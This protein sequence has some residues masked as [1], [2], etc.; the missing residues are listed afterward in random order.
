MH[1]LYTSERFEHHKTGKHPECSDR[2]RVLRELIDRPD[3]KQNWQI[4][5]P[6]KADRKIL[7]HIH[8]EKHIAAIEQLSMRGDGRIAADTVVSKASFDIGMNAECA[9]EIFSMMLRKL[10]LSSRWSRC[11]NLQTGVVV[12]E[13]LTS[14]ST[15][16]A[17]ARA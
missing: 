7:S 5:E 6:V 9:V 14:A 12:H 10:L 11:S 15:G 17:K 16:S 2:I 1:T 3:I 8:P 13:A 4:R